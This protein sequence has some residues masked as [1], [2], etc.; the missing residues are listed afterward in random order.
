[1]KDFT[2]YRR[3]A[4]W[5][6]LGCTLA[7]GLSFGQTRFFEV[8]YGNPAGP[9]FLF[10]MNTAYQQIV[11]T[12]APMHPYGSL[13]VGTDE[14]AASFL[15]SPRGFFLQTNLDG[16]LQLD[17]TFTD[18]YPNHIQQLPNGEIALLGDHQDVV[19]VDLAGHVVWGTELSG[20][21]TSD[22]EMTIDADGHLVIASD[23]QP[24]SPHFFLTRL[25]SHS[26]NWT[27][28]FEYQPQ[29]FGGISGNNYRVE[30]VIPAEDHLVVVGVAEDTVAGREYPWAAM[31]NANYD[32]V[33]FNE[34]HALQTDATFED[35][36]Y[37][38]GELYAAGRY[39]ENT[40]IQCGRTQLL[41][42]RLDW[43]S[44]HP[45]W[46]RMYCFDNAIEYPSVEV[47][48]HYVYL[49]ANFTGM[50]HQSIVALRTD[51]MGNPMDR[52]EFTPP[53]IHATGWQRAYLD[54]IPGVPT[55]GVLIGGFDQ[56]YGEPTLFKTPLDFAHCR[57]QV[58]DLGDNSDYSPEDLLPVNRRELHLN[59]TA[60]SPYSTAT[61]D[62]TQICERTVWPRGSF[63][64]AEIETSPWV[65]SVNLEVYPNP[66]AGRVTISW[67]SDVAQPTH[68]R[69]ISLTGAVVQEFTLEP[70]SQQL[71]LVDLP[72]GW[73]R[74]QLQQGS[75]S[76]SQLLRIQ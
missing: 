55:E 70:G 33:W 29:K 13:M 31:V 9:F 17:M 49:T 52:Q 4:L 75:R 28:T 18:F 38:Q 69:V 32:V 58:P 7:T 71:Q 76:Q 60:I 40:P 62:T 3:L 35:V 56:S 53:G 68:I 21:L 11:P 30:E 44:G 67:S 45:Q 47:L 54:M 14:H 8:Q 39:V 10:D 59:Q 15:P 12:K 1:M 2:P 51:D 74:V 6:W 25:E 57:N 26:G 36:A 27:G 42:S 22:D 64:G 34:Y 61:F 23:D 46:F 43:G 5:L 48:D 65:E 72:T 63:G 19:T 73:Y 37:F 16:G 66:S 24:T 41:L 20:V 50:T